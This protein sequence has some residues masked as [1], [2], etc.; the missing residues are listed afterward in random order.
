MSTYP[1]RA[2]RRR[3]APA[4]RK[5]PSSRPAPLPAAAP[6]EAPGLGLVDLAGITVRLRSLRTRPGAFTAAFDAAR[7]RPGYGHC[8]CTDPPRK[9][10]IRRAQHRFY[11]ASWPGDGANHAAGCTFHSS[12][13]PSPG[14]PSSKPAISDNAQGARVHLRVALELR[15]SQRVGHEAASNPSSR[16]AGTSRTTLL[17]LL[18]LLWERAG[19]TLYQ[20]HDP[21][22]RWSSCHD[23]LIA[24]LGDMTV[25]GRRLDQVLHVVPPYRPGA[26]DSFT[27]FFRARL[28]AQGS[29]VRRGLLLGEVKEIAA[30][31]HGHRLHLRHQGQPLLFTNAQMSALRRS[32]PTVFAAAGAPG[33]RR[34]MLALLERS[35]RGV[36][37]VHTAAAMLTNHTY[38]PA[39]S[40]YEVVM[41]DRLIAAGRTIRKP[42]RYQGEEEVFPDFVLPDDD[43]PTYVE[44]FGVRGRE[45]Y[46]QRKH[47]KKRYYLARGI[48]VIAWTVGTEPPLIPGRPALPGKESGPL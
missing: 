35:V 24:A 9:L 7:T 25:N 29:S 13:H 2:A 31:G 21:H 10:V 6:N 5:Q 8:L 38:L 26:P 28:T 4:A 15:T 30:T 40:S 41:A 20:P 11:L 46:E 14:S 44:V 1:T 37:T 48:P 33:S 43:P 34:I 17:A 47:A 32:H 23:R 36:V 12:Q 19:L 39:D 3:T 27:A 42:V 45:R 22:N 16:A 18:H